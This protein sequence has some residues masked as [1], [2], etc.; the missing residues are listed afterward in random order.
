MATNKPGGG[1][2]NDGGDGGGPGRPGDGSPA[3]PK[4]GVPKHV[5]EAQENLGQTAPAGR[6]RAAGGGVQQQGG[7]RPAGTTHPLQPVSPG[8]RTVD[9]ADAP[10]HIRNAAGSMEFQPRGTT[11]AQARPTIGESDG[12]RY[13]SSNGNPALA[14]DLNWREIPRPP[15]GP[16]PVAPNILY[17]HPEM[18]VAAEMRAQARAHPGEPVVRDI[19]VD[20][21]L[22]GTRTFDRNGVATCETLLADVLPAGSRF[23]VWTT[24]DGGATYQVKTYEGTG[25]FVR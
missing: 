14:D 3:H 22:C 18:Q 9:G 19:V 11:P 16:F 17:T 8:W 24:I 20:N 6:P 12:H 21:S 2:G 1:G 7:Q 10:Q 4:G 13:S 15:H 25:R 5:V 23:T